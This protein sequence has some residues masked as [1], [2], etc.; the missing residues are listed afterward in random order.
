MALQINLPDRKDV[1]FD[2]YIL[3]EICYI[4]HF[5][6]LRFFYIYFLYFIKNIYLLEKNTETIYAR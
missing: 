3:V 1:H 2:Q 4:V 6:K 5:L